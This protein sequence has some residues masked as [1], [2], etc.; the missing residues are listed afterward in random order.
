MTGVWTQITVDE[1][2]GLVYL[3][4]VVAEGR[5]SILNA[6]D[7]NTLVVDVA[8]FNDTTWF[9]RAGNFHKNFG[10]RIDYEKTVEVIDAVINRIEA[11]ERKLKALAS[12]VADRRAQRP[13]QDVGQPE[14]EHGV[15]LE[16]VV[17]D[18][19]ERDEAAEDEDRDGVAEVELFG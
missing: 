11:W 12:P 16:P 2:L 4:V 6:V 17:G 19:D 9:D 14:G 5:G 13:G 10:M 8:S 1:E 18:G 15:E 3:P 7:G